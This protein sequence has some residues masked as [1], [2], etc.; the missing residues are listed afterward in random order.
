[1]A[2]YHR[3]EDIIR[4]ALALQ[5]P[6]RGLCL[7]DVQERFEVGRRTAER[8]REAVDRLYPGLTSTKGG[9]GRKYWRLPAGEANGLIAWR[10]EEL[11]VLDVTIEEV[12]AAGQSERAAVLAELRDKLQGLS[13]AA[14][15]ALE[16]PAETLRRAIVDDRAVGVRR[17]A[18]AEPIRVHPHGVLGGSR[19]LLVALRPEYG[20]TSLIPLDEIAGVEL[21]EQ[22]FERRPE[23]DLRRHAVNALAGLEEGPGEVCWHIEASAEEVRSYEFH[24]EQT[25]EERE[26]GRVE[27]C[28]PSDGVV[29]MAWHLFAWGDRVEVVRSPILKHRF[30]AMMQ[31]MLRARMPA[32]RTDGAPRVDA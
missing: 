6:G 24:G 14:S 27:V 30:D 10:P 15:E 18:S 5:A 17:V 32:S 13:E 31:R 20:R 26:D 12:R 22:R 21:L 29:P 23:L 8:M 2:R 19:P 11:R 1:M 7:E 3:V 16:G 4:L 25:V 28:F 9:D